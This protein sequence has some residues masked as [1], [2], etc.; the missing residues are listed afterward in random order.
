MGFSKKASFFQ[1]FFI[2]GFGGVFSIQTLSTWLRWK[3]GI[4]SCLL[5]WRHCG[6]HQ[7]DGVFFLFGAGGTRVVFFEEKE[8]KDFKKTT[9]L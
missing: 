9:D 3:P 7:G 5:P 8:M 4:W 6:C 2:L 1:D